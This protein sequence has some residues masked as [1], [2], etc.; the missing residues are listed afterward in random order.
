M[1]G[2]CCGMLD[3]STCLLECALRRKQRKECACVCVSPCKTVRN[4]PPPPSP[5]SLPFSLYP[6]H[7]FRPHLQSFLWF[8]FVCVSLSRVNSKAEKNEQKGRCIGYLFLSSGS[9]SNPLLYSPLCMLHCTIVHCQI[10]PLLTSV[11][12]L[13]LFFLF[14]FLLPLPLLSFSPSH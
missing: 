2:S 13:F 9:L 8:P 12:P 1:V 5:V 10:H 14:V 4:R 6:F 11:F 3:R 7:S